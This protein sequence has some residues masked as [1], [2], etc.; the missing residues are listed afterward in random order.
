M[1][2]IFGSHLPLRMQMEQTILSQFQ[3]LPALQSE[4]C[5]LETLLG[6]DEEFGFE[7]YL[8]GY[9]LIKHLLKNITNHSNSFLFVIRSFSIHRRI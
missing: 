5:G 6:K 3:R 2:N 1:L 7:D 4:F 8:N 9:F